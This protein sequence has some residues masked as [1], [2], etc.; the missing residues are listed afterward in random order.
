L[1]GNPVILALINLL[2]FARRGC[3]FNQTEQPTLG[4]FFQRLFRNN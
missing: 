4:G 3:L 1:A 2:A